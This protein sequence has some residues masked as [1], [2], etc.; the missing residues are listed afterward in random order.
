MARR[1]RKDA[2]TYIAQNRAA[3]FNYAISK[4]YEATDNHGRNTAVSKIL[5]GRV[6]LSPVYD[7]SP[8]VLADEKS[9]ETYLGS[10]RAGIARV[11]R[12][13][14]EEDGSQRVR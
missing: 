14:A 11:C 6:E 12:W 9:N 10:T 5:D 13:L 2:Q 8:M 7:F 1:A 4:R 3:S